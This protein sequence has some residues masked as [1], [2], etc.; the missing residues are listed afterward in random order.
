MHV[1]TV[2]AVTAKLKVQN[3]VT[4]VTAVTQ[5]QS[6]Y[7]G[8]PPKK[9]STSRSGAFEKTFFK[10]F[11]RVWDEIPTSKMERGNNPTL[12]A[13]RGFGALESLLA[14]PT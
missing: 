5:N 3:I 8:A 10:K 6:A 13:I 4:A 12:H 11:F 2:T 9:L 14:P 1:T 7:T